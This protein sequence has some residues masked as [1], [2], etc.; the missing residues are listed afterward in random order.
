MFFFRVG[1]LWDEIRRTQCPL[2]Q[3]DLDQASAAQLSHF[4]VAP[5][6]FFSL[7]GHG[8]PRMEWYVE[9]GTYEI[10]KNLEGKKL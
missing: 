2:V 10:G 4:Q 9:R 7:S 6:W 3:F 1:L 5:P 8:A